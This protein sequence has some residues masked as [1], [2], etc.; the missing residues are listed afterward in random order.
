LTSRI[1]SIQ[2][3]SK[4]AAADSGLATAR[5]LLGDFYRDGVG[6]T[7]S[8]TDAVNWWMKAVKSPLNHELSELPYQ[9]HGLGVIPELRQ[10]CL[11]TMRISA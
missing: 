8:N 6:V 10:V 5:D 1:H 7:A 9:Y 11:P 2:I 4:E 3:D